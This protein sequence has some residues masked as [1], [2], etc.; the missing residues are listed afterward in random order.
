MKKIMLSFN[1]ETESDAKDII[2]YLKENFTI[3]EDD[4]SYISLRY[5]VINTES[6]VMIEIGQTGLTL[7]K[8]SKPHIA[9][10]IYN[11]YIYKVETW[12]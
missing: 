7:R 2:E 8:Y 5:I 11:H 4:V 9:V 12:L 1:K 3:I 10:H 6:D